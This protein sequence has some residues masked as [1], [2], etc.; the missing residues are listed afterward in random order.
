P[1]YERLLDDLKKRKV[2]SRQLDNLVL[3]EVRKDAAHRA[4]S[5]NKGGA[6]QAPDVDAV[7]RSARRIID[8]DDVLALFSQD[9][10]KHVAGERRN[11][12]LLYLIATSRLLTNPLSGG[13]KGS[14]SGGK[15]NLLQW[16]LRY[17]PDE[18]VVAFTALSE[19]ALLYLPDSL[20]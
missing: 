5:L 2:R 15:S 19:K 7:A 1:F 16:L 3:A 4:A 13:L 10:K 14:S 8:C 17:I 11:A 18:D 6:P 9:F 20:A 12:E